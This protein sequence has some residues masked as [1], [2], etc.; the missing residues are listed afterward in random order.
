MIKSVLFVCLGNICRSPTAEGIFQSYIDQ[1]GLREIVYCDSAGTSAHHSGERADERMREAA[2]QKGYELLS[3]SRAFEVSDFDDFDLVIAMDSSNFRNLNALARNDSDSSKIKMMMSY[4]PELQVTDVPD[5]YYGGEE[6]FRLV[7]D[8]LEVAC[9]KL[10][11]EV[12]DSHGG[13]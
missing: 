1:V 3:I 5:P 7:I 8:M 10:L 13:S 6:G 12:I 11:K 2:A 9:Q 4:A